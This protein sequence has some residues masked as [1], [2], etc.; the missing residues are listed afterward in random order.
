MGQPARR[1]SREDWLRGGLDALSREGVPGLRTE[2]LARQLGVTTGSFYWHFRDRNDF[3]KQLLDF[4]ADEMTVHVMEEM[5]RSGG[6]VRERVRGLFTRIIADRLARYET[7][8]RA[9]ALTYA[10]ARDAV[11]RVDRLRLDYV[12]E[13]LRGLGFRGAQPEMRARAL[14]LCVMAEPAFFVDDDEAARLRWLRLWLE[15]FTDDAGLSS[16][17]ESR[18]SG[19]H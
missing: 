17:S 13:L 19:R 15:L 11:A 18:A 9:W 8:V 1:L 5:D 3:Q 10:R 4:W 6:D 12:T 7:P 2:R 16:E 14:L